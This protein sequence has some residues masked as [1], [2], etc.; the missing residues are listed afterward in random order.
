MCATSLAFRE[1]TR[2]DADSKLH[3]LMAE[4]V[5]TDGTF[6]NFLSSRN[7]ETFRLSPHLMNTEE[8]ESADEAGGQHL[9][10]SG[11]T[12]DTRCWQKRNWGCAPSRA[13]REGAC[14]TA[15]TVY[16]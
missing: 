11:I 4:N 12:P 5:G 15:D 2:Q 6:T 14:G 3:Y 7:W 8:P 10:R 16:K 9:Q 13:F 1:G